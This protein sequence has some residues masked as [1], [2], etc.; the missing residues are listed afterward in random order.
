MKLD[1]RTKLIILVVTSLC[2]FL[3]NSI[4][5]ECVFFGV[6][7]LLLLAYGR[8]RSFFFFFFLFAL[9]LAAQLLL[10]PILPTA[11]GGV[12]FMFALYIR[13][14]IPSFMLGS[15]LVST[16]RVSAFLA[17]VGRLRLPKGFSI[18]LAITL[19]YFP[20]MQEEWHSIKEAMALR[21]LSASVGSILTHP[22]RTMEYVYVPMLVSASKISDEI[23][24]AAIT[25][26]IDHM[27]RRT[28]L[29]KV[30]FRTVDIAL[31]ILYAGMVAL[32]IW[33]AAKGVW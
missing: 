33:A 21:G 26:G 24:Q 8:W 25:R 19:R 18:S 15:L 1:P 6:P 4:L 3:N 11:A 22:T 31:M 9:L 16:T 13:K 10:V 17:A 32:L 23:S 20:T 7:A 2:A 12:I 5:V 30:G 29:E 14:L 27:E 28:T